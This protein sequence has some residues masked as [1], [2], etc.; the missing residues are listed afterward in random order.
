MVGALSSSGW[1]L[2]V[3]LD[4]QVIV[5]G[6]PALSSP[7]N[8]VAL[9]PLTRRVG[10]VSM[11]RRR[12]RAIGMTTALS[13]LLLSPAIAAQGP[14]DETSPRRGCT[15]TGTGGPDRLSGTDGADVICG[16]GGRDKVRAGAEADVVYGGGGNDLAFGGG[17]GDRL[18]GGRDD[19]ELLGNAGSDVLI[20]GRGGDHLV[21]DEGPDR[22]FGGPGEDGIS[23]T[24]G[25]DVAA[26]GARADFLCTWDGVGD[27]LLL[28]GRG[29]DRYHA[30]PHDVRR[31]VERH[32]RIPACG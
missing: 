10:P 8:H 32:Y 18:L 12:A 13:A 17:G 28:G 1:N 9:E 20:G 22:G 6:E 23:G 2:S 4:M 27:D 5:C 29:R 26:G 3:Q 31:S 14:R 11:R 7:R 25:L 16:R 15:I 30:D 21:L 19:D 24:T